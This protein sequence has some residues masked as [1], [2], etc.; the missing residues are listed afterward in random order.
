MMYPDLK[1]TMMEDWKAFYG[2]DDN[3][4]TN[5]P[6]RAD[7]ILIEDKGSG[8]SVQ[9]DLRFAGLP[10]LV[11]DPGLA[12]KTARAQLTAPMLEANTYYLLE[13]RKEPGKPMMW[14][15]PLL[16]QE[17]QFPNGEHDDL[18]DT[19]T[20]VNIYL[21]RAGWLELPVIKEEEINEV[22]YNA[23]NKARVNPYGQ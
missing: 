11:Y 15:R 14:A 5:K 16:K 7:A 17:E 19:H 21:Q 13:S 2:G 9:Q 23:R 3:D 10:V 6:V 1:R 22:D 12:S 8:K 4:P 20:Q 18:V